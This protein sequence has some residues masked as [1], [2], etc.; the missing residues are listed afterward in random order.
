[1]LGSRI[2]ERRL[3]QAMI[4]QLPRKG[5]A[6]RI[7]IGDG[8]KTFLELVQ[9]FLL[10]RGHDA[11]VASDGLECAEVLCEFAPDVVV[12]DCGL[13]WG[14]IQGVIALMRESPELSQIPAI[15]IAD[16]D[17]RNQFDN[18]MN[19]IHFKWLQKPFRLSEL[20]NRIESGNHPLRLEMHRKGSPALT[21]R[22]GAEY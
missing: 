2:V 11:R 17:P 1:V 15:L 21:T 22:S 18:T 4:P 19:S 3:Q 5:R 13:L 9:R 7:L 12:L 10:Q 16:E 6:M 20:L 8:D 14:G